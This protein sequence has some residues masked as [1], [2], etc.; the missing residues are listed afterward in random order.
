[1][2][3]IRIPP[4]YNFHNYKG[5]K[6]TLP[7]SINSNILPSQF[8]FRKPTSK[9][10]TSYLNIGQ[11][12]QNK[13]HQKNK[14]N[15][16]NNLIKNQYLLINS[17]LSNNSTI[18]TNQNLTSI[19]NYNN[20]R[21]TSNSSISYRNN[22]HSRKNTPA[23]N[24]TSKVDNEYFYSQN[25]KNEKNKNSSLIAS[26][27]IEKPTIKNF[28]FKQNPTYSNIINK[29]NYIKEFKEN[30]NNKR[31]VTINEN[32]KNQSYNNGYI[33]HNKRMRS[34]EN[35]T[36]PI[37]QKLNYR[38]KNIPFKKENGSKHIH[39]IS[40]NKIE[41]NSFLK[42]SKEKNK[43]IKKCIIQN[44]KSYKLET[45]KIQIPRAE[46]R[47]DLNKI[48]Q[49]IKI[50]KDEIE[51]EQIKKEKENKNIHRKSNSKSNI[52]DIILNDNNNDKSIEEVKKIIL[53]EP[54]VIKHSNTFVNERNNE[55]NKNNNIIKHN[56][57]KE[58][59][60]LFNDNNLCDL[61]DDFDDKFD[62]LNAIVRKIKFNLVIFNKESMF[63]K[64]NQMYNNYKE[65]FDYDYERNHF[66]KFKNL[67][68]SIGKDKNKISERKNYNNISFSTQSGSSCKKVFQNQNTLI[69][70]ISNKF[71]INNL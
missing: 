69:S 50:H 38:N 31:N 3:D 13:N 12:I 60:E 2:N 35:I 7:I 19:V 36:I 59:N 68:F 25:H 29:N 53:S 37:N 21:N 57:N 56:D 20:L 71:N 49:E 61:P 41:M 65:S 48:L 66:I 33:G 47:I 1:M 8:I 9:I 27:V 54:N 11:K 40:I 44:Q 23:Y 51:K 43:N 34:H 32:K 16:S 5:K 6:K 26:K 64:K 45:K 39:S 17:H 62:D 22:S 28:K 46:I 55:I 52:K 58:Y 42:R 70:P 18:K 67:Y 4:Q 30:F 10:A 24:K 14:S 63:S 15:I